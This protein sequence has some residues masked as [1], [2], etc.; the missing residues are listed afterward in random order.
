MIGKNFP[1]RGDIYLIQLDPTIGREIQKTRPCLIIS[2]NTQN[3]YADVICVAPITSQP[4]KQDR[5]FEVR[6]Q[7]EGKEGRVL[8]NQSRAIDKARLLKKMDTL[9]PAKMKEVNQAIKVVFG[10]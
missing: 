8:L 3:Q 9:S 4:Q 7:L 5:D 1:S 6:I 10:L 2:N